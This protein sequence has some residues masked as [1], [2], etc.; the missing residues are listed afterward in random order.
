MANLKLPG[1]IDIHTHMREPGAEQKEDWSSGT[2]AALAGGFT[3][4]L[5]MPN[6][7][8]AVIDLPSFEYALSKAQEKAHCDFALFLGASQAPPE[9]IW[10]IAPQ[11]AGLK[12]YLDQTYGDLKLSGME[13][14]FPW[15]ENWPQDVPLAV[16]AEGATLAAAILL[17]E[18]YQRPLHVCHVSRREEILLI[19]KAKERGLPV[20]CEVTPHHLFLST[21]DILR[22]GSGRSEVRPGLASP[23]D[24]RALWDN[25]EVID[26]FATDHAPHL[27]TEKDSLSHP[28]GFPGLETIVPL[29]LTAVHQG[30]LTLED[31]ITRLYQNPRRIFHIPEQI[32]TFIAVDVDH[33]WQ[34]PES[35]FF[36][37][38]DWSPFTGMPLMGRVEKVVL[39]GETTYQN[40]KILALPGSGQNCRNLSKE[41]EK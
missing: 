5:V 26:C 25:L 3:T 17:A 23:A 18:L 11:T 1:L 6:T 29:L 9:G 31:V 19:R 20:T 15:F 10:S 4:I 32:E 2:M 36:S 8:P 13:A 21:N 34:V 35:G 27:L 40:E 28:P 22:I 14:W 24:Q 39:R 7:Q 12:M 30:R 41:K 33:A 37:R 16:H 38:S